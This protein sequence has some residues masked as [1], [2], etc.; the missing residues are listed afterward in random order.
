MNEFYRLERA[1]EEICDLEYRSVENIQ[2][3]ISR[4]KKRKIRNED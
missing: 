1:K 4:D 3:E 2:S